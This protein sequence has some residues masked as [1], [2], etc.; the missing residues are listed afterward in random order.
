MLKQLYIYVLVLVV[1]ITTVGIP[2]YKHTCHVENVTIDTYFVRSSHC[3]E[4]E[5]EPFEKSCCK[6]EKKHEK[7]NLQKKCCSEEQAQFKVSDLAI[8]HVD[9]PSIEWVDFR[10][11]VFRIN[12]SHFE[13][14]EKLHSFNGYPQPPPLSNRNRL[15]L[16]NV[17]RC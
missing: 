9:L 2:V 7:E 10:P 17:W 12:Y 16:L 3:E 6:A 13:I 15:P 4:M 5:P 8:H 1:S 11:E 14:P